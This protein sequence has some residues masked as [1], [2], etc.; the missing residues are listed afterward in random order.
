MAEKSITSRD[1]RIAATNTMLSKTIGLSREQTISI[2]DLISEGPIEGLV[3]G[4]ASIF[5][6]DDR[7]VPLENTAV[8]NLSNSSTIAPS[9]SL[10]FGS[11]SATLIGTIPTSNLGV[12]NFRIKE[13]FSSSINVGSI[14]PSQIDSNVSALEVSTPTAFFTADMAFN[15]GLPSTY[16]GYF[17]DL[18]RLVIEETGTIVPGFLSYVDSTNAIF[19][20]KVEDP[21]LLDIFK[22][23]SVGNT[24]K[25]VID[26]VLQSIT[27]ATN[28]ITLL[29]A[30]TIPT[31]TYE[32]I[33]GSS[34]LDDLVSQGIQNSGAVTYQFRN[35]N[36]NQEPIIDLGGTG[37][38][39]IISTTFASQTLINKDNQ[40]DPSIDPPESPTLILKGSASTATGFDLLLPRRK[41]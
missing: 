27:S 20:S 14:V 12:R 10:T 34:I 16:F 29:N 22:E 26:G 13:V 31:G 18:V 5:L 11:T 40:S 25:I 39:S 24:V 6:N 3:N 7:I 23:E 4:E 15:N 32:I 38:V 8:S 33:I 17:N 37:S 36:A 21:I 30:S 41:K 19:S 28:A 9:I 1:Q 2:T 35:G